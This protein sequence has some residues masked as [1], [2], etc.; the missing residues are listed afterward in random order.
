LYCETPVIASNAGGSKELIEDGATGLL[1]ES[2]NSD[3][4]ALKMRFMKVHF[5]DLKKKKLRKSVEKFDANRVCY[6]VETALGLPH[7]V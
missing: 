1:F 4:L 6:Q 2:L 3:D 7:L 5:D